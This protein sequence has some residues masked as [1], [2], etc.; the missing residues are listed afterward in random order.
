MGWPPARQPVGMTRGPVSSGPRKDSG[1]SGCQRVGRHRILA[2][3]GRGVGEVGPECSMEKGRRKSRAEADRG[4]L[5]TPLWPEDKGGPER[6]GPHPVIFPLLSALG[7]RGRKSL[8]SA[9]RLSLNVEHL[10][11]SPDPP[12][13]DV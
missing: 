2:A 11:G 9:L 3:Q 13:R 12:T 4:L 5:S 6:L 8:L 10:F 1:G 7:L